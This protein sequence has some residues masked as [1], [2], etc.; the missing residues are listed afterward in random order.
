M[1]KSVTSK[2]EFEMRRVF[3]SEAAVVGIPLNRLD[4]PEN[5][6]QR[7]LAS[8]V[9]NPNLSPLATHGSS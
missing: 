1:R 6:E 8:G 2:T 5:L 9:A 3:V 4:V 7:S